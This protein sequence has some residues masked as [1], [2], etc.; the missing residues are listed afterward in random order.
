MYYNKEHKEKVNNRGDGYTYI[1]S[2]K[3]KEI[4]IDNKN[5]KR[6]HNYILKKRG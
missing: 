5:K 6:N 3:C 1:G 2:Y 4:T